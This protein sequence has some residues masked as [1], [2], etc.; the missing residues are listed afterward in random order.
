M[1]RAKDR[2]KKH[3][4]SVYLLKRGTKLQDVVEEKGTLQRFELEIPGA[5]EA[6]LMVRASA[7]S[8]PSWVGLFG[9][10]SKASLGKLYNASNAAILLVRAKTASFALTFGFGK[11]LLKPG[12]FDEIFGLRVTLNAID[13]KQ[14]RTIDRDSLDVVGRRTREQ[15]ARAGTI[16]EFGINLDQDLVRAVT[17]KPQDKTLGGILSGADGL[18]IHLP[19]VSKDLG[20]WFE[21]LAALNA[22][23]TYQKEFSWI[24][25]VREVKDPVLRA[26]LDESIVKRLKDG[27]TDRMWLAVPEVIDWDDFGGFR[28]TGFRHRDTYDDIYMPQFL[29]ICPDREDCTIEQLRRW[30]VNYLDAASEQ[31]RDHWSVYQCLY[32]E[33]RD[34][35]DV[36]LLNAGKW[37]KVTKSFVDEIEGEIKPLLEKDEIPDQLPPCE[38]RT[39]GEY[40][41]A[42]AERD[43]ANIA[44]LDG[45]NIRYGGGRSQIECCDLFTKKHSLIHVKRYSGSSVLSHLFA[46]GVVAAEAFA[47]DA[48]FR[49]AVNNKLPKGHKLHA[50]NTPPE[51]D[52]YRVVFAIISKAH[53]PLNLPFFSKVSLRNAA[54]RLRMMRYQVAVVGIED[55]YAGRNGEQE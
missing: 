50:P 5:R 6:I 20:A 31:T 41:L 26:K 25:N 28:Y 39:E 32:A 27:S 52:Q 44:C 42:V 15:V 40:N 21:R 29:E 43:K 2:K 23:K 36:Y 54:R 13:A 45:K 38:Q 34:G 53:K 10:Q 37:Y 17:G 18:V 35:T 51:L 4:L 47:A 11:H 9:D 46:Q 14:I 49:G 48:Q 12:A 24:D 8:T 19:V 1:P 33:A 55:R 7:Q 30:Q 16:A 3:R 22:D